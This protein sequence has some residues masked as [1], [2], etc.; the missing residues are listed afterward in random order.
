MV[1]TPAYH[2]PVCHGVQVPRYAAARNFGSGPAE[3]LAAFI[4]NSDG[5]F[6]IAVTKL[7]GDQN[8]SRDLFL[9][10]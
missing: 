9:V 4:V 3:D 10:I 7:P 5:S 8:I 1:S 6:E 2:E